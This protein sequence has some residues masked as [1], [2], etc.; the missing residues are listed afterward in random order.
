MTSTEFIHDPK[1]YYSLLRSVTREIHDIHTVTE[2]CVMVT[3]SPID[4]YNGGNTST[5]L[6]IAAFTTSHARLVLLEMMNRLGDRLI[7][8]GKCVSVW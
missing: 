3:S 2:N 7:Y 1:E 5:N 8:Y 4:E 6:A